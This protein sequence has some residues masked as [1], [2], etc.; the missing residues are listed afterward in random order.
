M[1]KMLPFLCAAMLTTSV[2]D[3]QNILLDNSFDPGIGPD[4]TVLAVSI[5]SDGKIMVGG[6][7][8]QFNNGSFLGLSAVR[9]NSDGTI[10]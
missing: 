8:D 4:Q 1:K 5:Q 2:V 9:L 3:A 6:L 10:G 7:F